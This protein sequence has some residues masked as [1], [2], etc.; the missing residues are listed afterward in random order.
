MPAPQELDFWGRY[1][2]WV[3]TTRLLLLKLDVTAGLR[4]KLIAAVMGA[5]IFMILT[6]MVAAL[7]VP[8]TNY[9]S[10]IMETV[11]SYMESGERERSYNR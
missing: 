9:L 10:R 6:G 5:D 4:P 2:D 1:V 8:P 3:V 11:H 7:E